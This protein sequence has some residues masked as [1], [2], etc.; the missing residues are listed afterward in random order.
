MGC[1]TSGET[2]PNNASEEEEAI[3]ASKLLKKVLESNPNT[4]DNAKI[5]IWLKYSDD[6]NL[7]KLAPIFRQNVIQGNLFCKLTNDKLKNEM[8]I[9]QYGLRDDFIEARNSL[10]K[11]YTNDS[12]INTNN[13]ANNSG[14][15]TQERSSTEK[16]M[17]IFKA[18]VNIPSHSSAAQ[19]AG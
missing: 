10:L 1:S 3:D 15:D 4:W 7:S 14:T 11:Q 17:M 18:N 6:E 12:S 8:N 13:S 9:T 5:L 2:T 19:I 16:Q